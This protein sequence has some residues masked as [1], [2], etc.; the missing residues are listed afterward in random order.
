MTSRKLVLD[1]LRFESPQRIPRQAWILPWA[2]AHHP[3]QVALLRKRFP[4]DILAAPAVYTHPPGTTGDRYAMGTYIDEW[5]CR[6]DIPEE[7]TIGLVSSPRI[8]RW[9]DLEDFQVPENILTLDREAVNDFCASTDRFVLAGTV[10]RPFERLQFLRTMEQALID[11]M[12]QPPELFT[13]L[14]RIHSLYLKEVEA[15]AGTDVDGINLMDDWGTQTGLLTS[16]DIFRRIFKPMYR[17]Y[18]QIARAH[19]KAVFMHSDGYIHDIIPDLIEVGIEALNAQVFCM[20]ISRLS[21]ESAG[22]LTFWGEVDRQLTLAEG[23]TKDVEKAV[24]IIWEM[25]FRGGGVIAQCE[26]GLCAKPE[27]IFTVFKTWDSIS[28]EFLGGNP[29]AGRSG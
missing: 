5:G 22:K 2:E 16:P 23:T 3:R 18:A 28:R 12:E 9:E 24:H 14:G 19:G 1:T 26:F 25:F 11:L 21:K 7:G 6:F 27:N 10:Q 15:W 4:D 13:L 17:E 8:R 20:D 29:A